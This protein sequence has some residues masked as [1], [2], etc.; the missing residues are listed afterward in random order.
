MQLHEP[1]VKGMDTRNIKVA[2][3]FRL[4][5]KIKTFSNFF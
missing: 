1:A 5:K 4:E 2:F 3:M